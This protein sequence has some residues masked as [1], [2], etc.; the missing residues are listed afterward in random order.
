LIGRKEPLHRNPCVGGSN[1]SSTARIS[2]PTYGDH[3][4]FISVWDATSG[5]LLHNWLQ[6]LTGASPFG[7]SITVHRV[8]FASYQFLGVENSTPNV[9]T[10]PKTSIRR[11]I[12]FRL[13]GILFRKFRR[14][15]HRREIAG[16][17][18]AE[19]FAFP[20]AAKTRQFDQCAGARSRVAI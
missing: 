14:S 6:C 1:P 13:T 2:N 8:D 12:G 10:A 20:R 16:G 7:K 9:L 11:L 5:R 15:L 4:C 19:G 3:Q 17:D 18:V